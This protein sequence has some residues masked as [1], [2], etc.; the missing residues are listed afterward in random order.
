MLY[1]QA[2]SPKTLEL[3]NRLMNDTVF[4]RFLLVGGT[5][6]SLQFGHRVSLDLDLFL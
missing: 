5:A 6:L 4:N 2:V 3:L 1:T